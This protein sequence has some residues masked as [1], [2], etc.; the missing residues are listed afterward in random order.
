MEKV[1][2]KSNGMKVIRKLSISDSRHP[3]GVFLCL[4]GANFEIQ[5]RSDFPVFL[6]VFKVRNTS[7]TVSEWP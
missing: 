6:A 7:R 5:I 2:Q 3:A 1:S 4:C